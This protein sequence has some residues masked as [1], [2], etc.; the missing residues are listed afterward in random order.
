MSQFKLFIIISV[1]T[2]LSGLGDS[3]GFIHASR[4]WQDSGIVWA[5]LWKSALGFG[6]GI[7]LYW[8][9]LK[10][11]RSAGI[12]SPELQTTIWFAVTLLGV[13]LVSGQFFQWHI[14]EQVVGVGVLIGITWLLVRT[15]G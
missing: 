11:M 8:I 9:V 3:R 6:S 1:V 15:G 14:T 2:I 10:Y 12:V 5:E 4:I 13:A 7:S